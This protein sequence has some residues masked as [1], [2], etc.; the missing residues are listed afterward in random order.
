MLFFGILLLTKLFTETNLT[1]DISRFA[2]SVLFGGAVARAVNSPGKQVSCT[3]LFVRKIF[4]K[5]VQAAVSVKL[6]PWALDVCAQIPTA[7]R[8][9]IEIHFHTI[10][11]GYV[12]EYMNRIEEHMITVK[13]LTAPCRYIYPVPLLH[14]A[15][16]SVPKKISCH[17]VISPVGTLVVSYRFPPGDSHIWF[18]IASHPKR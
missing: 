18:L 13:N 6:S 16:T 15:V 2:L 9:F 8:K 1:H 17:M 12:D 3:P 11:L 5:Y 7:M 14:S 4:Y 10:R